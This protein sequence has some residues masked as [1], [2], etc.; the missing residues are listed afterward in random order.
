MNRIVRETYPVAD[1]PE[2]S[3]EGLS[4]EDSVEVTLEP[5]GNVPSPD[6]KGFDLDL[7]LARSPRTFKNVEEIVGHI[8]SIREEWN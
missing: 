1:L 6:K 2:T 8:R 4:L 7:L 3:R 5:D